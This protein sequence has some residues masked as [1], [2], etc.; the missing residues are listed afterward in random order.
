MIGIEVARI[1]ED[2][3]FSDMRVMAL[4]RHRGGRYL[5][6]VE[7]I[8]TRHTDAGE[9]VLSLDLDYDQAERTN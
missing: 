3:T 2:P 7:H 1:C 9:V 6:P 5:V 8:T 4:V